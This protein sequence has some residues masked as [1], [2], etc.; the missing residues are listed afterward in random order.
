MVS[1]WLNH[2]VLI[3]ISIFIHSHTYGSIILPTHSYGS[4]IDYWDTIILMVTDHEMGL[5]QWEFQD[6]KMEVR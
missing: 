3:G 6:P 1:S 4:I 2:S 5:F